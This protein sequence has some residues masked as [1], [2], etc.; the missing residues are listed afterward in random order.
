M[1]PDPTPHHEDQTN[2]ST[3]AGIA[4]WDFLGRL[5]NFFVLFVISVFLTRLL[6]PAEFGSFAVVLA[7]ISLSG[8]FIDLGFRSAIIQ[9]RNISQTQLSTV[10]FIN[11]LI[12]LGLASLLFFGSGF[13]ERFY[14]I[15]NLS[16]YLGAASSLF[17]LNA[18][19]LVPGGLLQ[20]QLRLKEL[21]VINT[22]AA[23]L[24]GIAALAMAIR[25]YGIWS[26]VAP[27]I[28]LGS[29][30]C[31]GVF[32]RTK[33]LPSMAFTVRSI[34][35][36]WN[37][38]IRLFLAGLADTIFTRLD[39]FIIGKIFPLQILGFYNR[40]QTLD[41][42]VKTFSS[43][44]TTSVAFPVIANMAEDREAVRAFYL[45]CLNVI[46]FLAFLLIGVLFLTCFDIVII[47]F[48]ETWLEVGFYFRI[49]ALTAFVY[50]ISALMVNLIAALGNSAAFLKLELLKKAVLFPAYISFLFGGVMLFLVVLGI[51]YLVALL[52]NAEFV[53]REI[54]VSL[55]IQFGAIYKYAGLGLI[56]GAAAYAA[57]YF[58]DNIY[59]HLIAASTIFSLLYLGLCYFLK[60]SGTLEITGRLI[61]IYN[62]KRNT[63]LS[64]AS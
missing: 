47:L 28:I 16:S 54:D 31:I 48:T 27:Q 63:N 43:T 7:V 9:Q 36:L 24:S 18:L 19:A 61:S 11:L 3:I 6:T 21:S 33:W 59:L 20:K 41:S 25:G 52:L 34:V 4:I 10:F 39:V 13:I 44:T 32:W 46:S 29:A 53:R 5:A 56:A 12:G 42:L 51:L 49:M 15:D 1:T 35:P 30:T 60:L 8:I 26:L 14:G 58:I 40:A 50:P 38:G 64:S 55:K 17:V 2:R 37:Y 23:A 22:I 57:S 62:A 45:R